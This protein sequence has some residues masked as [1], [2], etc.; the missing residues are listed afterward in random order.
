MN[1]INSEKEK[2]EIPTAGEVDAALEDTVLEDTLDDGENANKDW[3]TDI[4]G[5][6]DDQGTDSRGICNDDVPEGNVAE[7]DVAEGDV[8]EGDERPADT[9]I[10]GNDV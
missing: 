5:G 9:A 10:Q 3:M 7:G 6:E 1:N 2:N 4:E 8:A